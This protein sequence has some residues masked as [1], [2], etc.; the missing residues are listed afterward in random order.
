MLELQREPIETLYEFCRCVCIPG[1]TPAYGGGGLRSGNALQ[2]CQLRAAGS[3]REQYRDTRRV[4][5]LKARQH[6]R[7]L[8]KRS[9]FP[10]SANSGDDTD[11]R[12][13]AFRRKLRI[14]G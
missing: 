8:R 11:W 7:D 13:N 6:G 10:F 12:D 5:R 4:A 2:R 1:A 3:V 9:D 14:T